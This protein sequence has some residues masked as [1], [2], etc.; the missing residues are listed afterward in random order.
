MIFQ[1]QHF[2]TR[3]SYKAIRMKKIL[4]SLENIDDGILM[5]KHF[6]INVMYF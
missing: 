4:Y 3:Y 1:E 5:D 6:E 2:G